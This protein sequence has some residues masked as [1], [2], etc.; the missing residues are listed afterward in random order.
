MAEQRPVQ[1]QL[2]GT[3]PA[4]ALRITNSAPIRR[5]EIARTKPWGHGGS[6]RSGPETGGGSCFARGATCAARAG[7]RTSCCRRGPCPDQPPD[8]RRAVLEPKDRRDPPEQHLPQDGRHDTR[9]PRAP[10]NAPTQQRSR[11]PHKFARLPPWTGGGATDGARRG[12]AIAAGGRRECSHRPASP[13]GSR[14]NAAHVPV[15]AP[16]R[17]R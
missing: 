7:A 11:D 2:I 1:K 5:P 14:P 16:R 10:S 15:C 9:H 6:G 17:Q 3:R 8:R 12:R 4:V 13:A